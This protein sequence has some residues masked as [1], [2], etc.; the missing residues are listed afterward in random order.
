[1]AGTNDERPE[2]PVDNK[3]DPG[4]IIWP[5]WDC[6]PRWRV[7]LAVV[8]LGVVALVLGWLVSGALGVVPS[9]IAVLGWSGIRLPGAIVV[10]CLLVAS[11]A[12]GHA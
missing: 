12:L 6:L 7:R 9:M 4:L 2:P 3:A 1:M 11:L 8:A 10:G 5:R